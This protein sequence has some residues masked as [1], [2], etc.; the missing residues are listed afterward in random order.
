MIFISRLQQHGKW[1]DTFLY[2]F[3]RIIIKIIV[4]TTIRT[5]QDVV[6]NSTEIHSWSDCIGH[7][8]H[9]FLNGSN[10]RQDLK[11]RETVEHIKSD[12]DRHNEDSHY[13]DKHD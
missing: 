6:G 11:A 9:V 1:R 4:Y 3:I 5:V 2:C 12:M 8:E 7:F 10:S 13:E